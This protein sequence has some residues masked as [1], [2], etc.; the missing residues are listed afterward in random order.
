MGSPGSASLIRSS[1]DRQAMGSVASTAMTILPGFTARGAGKG[2]T[3]SKTE[4]AAY[5]ATAT[6]KVGGKEVKKTEG[7]KKEGQRE[8]EKEELGNK[9]AERDVVLLDPPTQH[10]LFFSNYPWG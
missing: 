5:P 1:I 8:G 10:W 2:F 4:I 3:G 6:Q 9:L 7:G